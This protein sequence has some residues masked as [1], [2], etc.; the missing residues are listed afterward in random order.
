[1]EANEIKSYE[2]AG[3]IA[4]EVRGFAR[5]LI[6]PGMK[7]IDIAEAIDAKILELGGNSAFPVNLSL[8]EIAAHYTPEPEDVSIADGLL[9]VDLGVQVEGYIADC[10]F[11][12]DLSEEKKFEE[13][14]SANEEVLEAASEIIR[15]KMKVM[16]VGTAVQKKLKEINN[17]G[18][19]F[20]IIRGLSGHSLGKDKIHAGITISNYENENKTL[21]DNMA[22]AIEPFLTTGTGEIYEGKEGGIYMLQKDAPVR[23]PKARKLLEF[24]KENYK[25]RP[26]CLRWLE[27]ENFERAKGIL[28]ILVKQGILHSFSILVEKSKAPVSQAENSFIISEETV[29]NFTK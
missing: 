12:L 1:M 19:N 10:A 8:N 6:E 4:S 28:D 18:N 14:I 15:P 16:D 27:K 26:F 3:E 29:K 9:K 20:S 17:G 5:K 2:K 13:M 7:L 21:L 22:F 11:S 24:I 25:T 23:D